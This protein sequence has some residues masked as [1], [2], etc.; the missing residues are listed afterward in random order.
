M[1][2]GEVRNLAQRSAQAT[3]EIKLLIDESSQRVGTGVK[4][5]GDMRDTMG[6]IMRSVTQAA[7]AV[8][9][10]TAAFFSASVG[11]SSGASH[12]RSPSLPANLADDSLLMFDVPR[13]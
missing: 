9:E 11:F 13:L 7:T 8:A 2:A 1:V 3:K 12:S 6:G 5:A 10:I 4:L